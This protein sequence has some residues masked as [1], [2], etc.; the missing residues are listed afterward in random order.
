MRSSFSK[1]AQKLNDRPPNEIIDQTCLNLIK[2]TG[3]WLRQVKE[4]AKITIS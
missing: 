1:P 3:S 2:F 4:K